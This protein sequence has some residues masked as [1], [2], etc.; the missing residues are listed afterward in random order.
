MELCTS[1]PGLLFHSDVPDG[2]CNWPVELGWSAL[3]SG[4]LWVS[5]HGLG[6]DQHGEFARLVE[7]LVVLAPRPLPEIGRII[8]TVWVFVIAARVVRK[9]VLDNSR[10]GVQV[11]LVSCADVDRPWRRFW[12]RSWLARTRTHRASQ[13]EWGGRLVLSPRCDQ[14]RRAA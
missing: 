10:D 2:V 7:V 9:P 1:A 11:V 3:I 4:R 8:V 6:R 12:L 14:R 13:G 5:S